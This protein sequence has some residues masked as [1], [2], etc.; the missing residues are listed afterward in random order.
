MSGPVKKP[1][2]PDSRPTRAEQARA[3]RRRIIAA[4]AEQFIALG[5]GATRLD[6]V[7]ERSG[8][9]V[10]TVFFHFGNKRTLLKE[11]L[12][13]AAVGDD[14]PVALLERPWIEQIQQETDPQR[15]IELWMVTGRAIVE[16]VAPLMRVVRG[17][18][19][20]DP[21]LAA[22]WDTNQQQTRTAYGFLVQ[23]L[24]GRDALRPGLGVDQA[25]DIAFVLGNVE[26]YLQFS[27]VCGWTLDEW[28]QR[29]GELLGAAL[30]GSAGR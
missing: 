25:V 2:K 6:Q 10:Q 4:A 24:A 28:Q 16:R 3:T 12:D 22:Q 17:A 23:L 9:A 7:A 13:V 26:T 11:A 20:T 5:Y 15:I 19:G 30:L 1:K 8:V 27:E 29:V 21:E 14:E 18:T